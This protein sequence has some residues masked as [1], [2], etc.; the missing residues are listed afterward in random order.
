MNCAQLLVKISPY[1]DSEL[2]YTELTAFK[3]HMAGCD[4]CTELVTAMAG[5]K[6]ALHDSIYASLP[7]DF[8]TRLQHRVRA[9]VNRP[10]SPWRK[11]MEPRFG[12]FSPLS[13]SGLAAAALAVAIIGVSLF[14]VE[15]APIVA[16]P[17]SSAQ[18]ATPPLS[19]PPRPTPNPPTTPVLTTAPEDSSTLLRDSARR[20]FSRQI[21]YVNTGDRP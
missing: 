11:L 3:G 12:G 6:I 13:V 17:T 15:S 16:P 14:T 10:Q 2:S 1:L 4:N 18:Q 7:A 8:V 19:A 20:D 21:K 5:T 9:E